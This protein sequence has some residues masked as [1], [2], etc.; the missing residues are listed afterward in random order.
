MTEQ[1]KGRTWLLSA[2]VQGY[3]LGLAL[4]FV[5]VL[6]GA[7]AITG[8][9]EERTL[10]RL[11]RGL[12]GLGGLVAEKVVFVALVAGLI[13]LL[14]AVVF[15]VVIEVGSVSGGQP[16]ER[17]PLVGAGLVLAAAAFGA[18]GVLLGTLARDASGAMLLAFLIGLPVVLLGIVPPG[19]FA[20]AGTLS[21]V[22]PFRH[23]VDL[24]TTALYDADPW[25]GALREGT[26]LLALTLVF[27][28][29]ARLTARRLLI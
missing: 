29:L 9:R 20:L 7:G 12:V 15:G 8:E 24:A 5:A 6:L 1:E 27:A 2:Q 23:A 21:S 4:A 10:G 13:G 19:S 11:V 26:W 28:L 14:L 16:W 3:A 22:V 25:S 17:L 18:L